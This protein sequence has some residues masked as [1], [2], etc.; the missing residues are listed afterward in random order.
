MAK[1]IATSDFE[2]IN[3]PGMGELVDALKYAYR[4]RKA[5]WAGEMF[6]VDFTVLRP[7]P[8]AAN[9]VFRLRITCLRRDKEHSNIFYYQG[10]TDLSTEFAVGDQEVWGTYNTRERTGTMNRP[11]N[12]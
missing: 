12:K 2:V 8:R 6:A 9:L 5:N 11:K 10:E 7:H 4:E 3:G 1:K